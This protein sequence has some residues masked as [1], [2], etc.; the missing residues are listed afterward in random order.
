MNRVVKNLETAAFN[1]GKDTQSK[2]SKATVA[3]VRE[4]AK[5]KLKDKLT[6]LRLKIQAKQEDREALRDL[7]REYVGSLPAA[8]KKDIL[9][10]K[11]F[12]DAIKTEK[13]LENALDVVDERLTEYERKESTNKLKDLL[14]KLD[15]NKLRPEFRD[16]LKLVL[17]GVTSMTGNAKDKLRG[18]SDFIDKIISG[19]D[20]E[21][22]D[23]NDRAEYAGTLLL[24][25]A[26][27]I[28][29]AVKNLDKKSVGDLTK[30]EADALIDAIKAIQSLNRL[31]NKI[32]T[33]RGRV[34]R[35]TRIANIVRELESARG[36]YMKEAE[37]VDG[38]K[39]QTK[40]GVF[41]LLFKWFGWSVSQQFQPDLMADILSGGVNTKFWDTFY[42][43]IAESYNGML[44]EYYESQ[45]YMKEV[46]RENGID[47]ETAQGR[48]MLA[49]MSRV[50][51]G[52]EGRRHIIDE[53]GN[54]VLYK[55]VK[56]KTIWFKLD[57]GKSLILTE[58]EL[59]DLLASFHDANTLTQIL[60][61]K[62]PVV[63]KGGKRG[64]RHEYQL[65]AKDIVTIQGD[66]RSERAGNLAEAMVLYANTQMAESMER[67]SVEKN[68]FSIVSEET[69]WSRKRRVEGVN[70]AEELSKR[71][72]VQGGI[73]SAG[74][75]KKRTGGSRPIEISDGF[76][77]FSNLS[78]TTAGM[79]HL[80][81]AV[82]EARAIL[83]SKGVSDF[84]S[85]AKN[86]HL[87]KEYWDNYFDSI[88]SEVVGG[89]PLSGESDRAGRKLRNNF[90]KGVLAVNPRVAFYQ[91]VSL[92]AAA[93]IIPEQYVAAAVGVRGAEGIGHIL[94]R[95]SNDKNKESEYDR[96]SR[97]MDMHSPYLRFRFDASSFGIVSEAGGVQS[98]QLLG[99]RP[100]GEWGMYGIQ[101]M[102]A[103]AIRTAWRASEFWVAADIRNGNFVGDYWE[104][105]ARRTEDVVKRTQPTMDVVHTSGIGREVK[106]GR[107]GF[108]ASLLTLFNTQ[109]NKNI[110]MIARS[111]IKAKR[112]EISWASLSPV[113]YIGI[114]SPLML[115]LIRELYQWVLDDEYTTDALNDRLD[116]AYSAKHVT[117]QLVDIGIGNLPLGN[118]LSYPIRKGLLEEEDE[119]YSLNHPVISTVE[120]AV[121]STGTAVGS[122][123][124]IAVSDDREAREKAWDNLVGSMDKPGA[125]E[126]LVVTLGQLQGV[127]LAPLFKQTSQWTRSTFTETDSMSMLSGLVTTNRDIVKNEKNNEVRQ[128]ANRRLAWLTDTKKTR[129][130]GEPT[131]RAKARST[132][133]S[134]TKLINTL[135][136]TVTEMD[137]RGI[138]EEKVQA[139]LDLIEKHKKR[140]QELVVKFLEAYTRAFARKA[141]EDTK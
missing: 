69:W 53:H 47:V 50:V 64:E 17:A 54:K 25:D 112:G 122:V 77:K 3:L 138:S 10:T 26:V 76:A 28:R 68:G 58:A 129:A 127:Q 123:F 101:A 113:L 21:G 42:G 96:V 55:K 61:N 88:A 71:G 13:G 89:I 131:G 117:S 6:S 116:K 128:E 95:V 141:N 140:R 79:V 114:T 81:P 15:P 49:S 86:G 7:L 38:R 67:W 23:E 40:D 121:K 62:A 33:R 125:V 63:I 91:V 72:I 70:E 30:A 87:A 22:L 94:H 73:D 2:R 39:K 119:Y 1:E 115:I 134:L 5:A 19:K 35:A 110:N 31:K 105:V 78:W 18:V 137:R 20:I 136:S 120:T 46:L 98:M 16:Q 104:E 27:G 60:K 107:G 74:I 80:G 75:S 48:S 85:N 93:T 126:K 108:W 99:T 118:M 90:T 102:D 43:E 41:K 34:N 56:A 66:V 92:N 59:I 100:T 135:K 84:F 51:S 14:D 106:T 97:L 83:K 52:Q 32:I 44:A 36:K 9:S 130:S 111:L 133:N 8:L 82:R 24:L 11:K 65:T 29:D 124:D 4:K 109:R 45:D 37:S 12:T 57:S 139:K 103:W 132:I